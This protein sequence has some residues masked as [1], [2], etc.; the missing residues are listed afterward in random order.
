MTIWIVGL[1]VYVLTLAF[2]FSLAM[3]A[4]R[5]TPKKDERCP[6]STHSSQ[7]SSWVYRSRV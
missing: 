4:D 2:M 5:P 6:V 1:V 3:A 7:D